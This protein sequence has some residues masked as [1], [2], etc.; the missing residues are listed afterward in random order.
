[1]SDDALLNVDNVSKRFCRI[2]KRLLWTGLQDLHGGIPPLPL[3]PASPPPF[4][5]KLA[6]H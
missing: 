6:H 5:A 1:M 4:L 2:L 3:Q